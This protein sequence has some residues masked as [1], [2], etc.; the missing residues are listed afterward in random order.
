MTPLRRWAPALRVARREAGRAKGRSAVVLAMIALPVLGVTAADIVIQTSEITGAE[1][2]D[3]RIGGADALVLVQPRTA[4]V[5]QTADPDRGTMTLRGGRRAQPPGL[6]EIEDALGRDIEAVEV[7]AQE[8]VRF[9]TD[10][11][12]A[13]VEI[14]ETDLTSPLTRGLFR[15]DE[16]RVP[17]DRSEIVINHDLAE[18]GFVLGD[19]MTVV[20]GPDLTVVG[21]GDNTS[22]RGRGMAVAQ[23][24]TFELTERPWNRTWLVDAGGAVTWEDVRALNEVGAMALSR[25]VMKDPPSDAELHPSMQGMDDAPVGSEDLAVVGLIVV[26]ALLE[27]VLLAGPAFAVIARRL[28]HSLALMAASGATP[29][30]ARRVVL[31]S[32]LVLG[33]VGTTLGVGLGLLVGWLSLPLVQRFSS[34]FFGPYDVPWLHLAGVAGFGMLSAVLAAV[35]PAWIASRQD[36][37]AVLAGRRGDRRPSR[38][39]PILGL[40]LLGGGVAVAAYGAVQPDNGELLIAASAV[41]TVLGMILLVPVVVAGLARL[42]AVLPLPVRYAV[43]DAARHRARTVPAVAAVAATVVGVVALGIANASDAEQSRATY[44]PLMP[45]GTA[46]VAGP[47]DSDWEGSRAALAE[48]LPGA[49]ISTV[50]GVDSNGVHR[51]TDVQFRVDGRAVRLHSYGSALATQAPIADAI[52]PLVPELGEAERAA[53]DRILREGGAVVFTSRAPTGDEVTVVAREYGPRG[54]GTVVGRA[55]VPAVMIQLPGHHS[56]LQA[57]LSPEAAAAVGAEPVTAG[58]VVSGEEITADQERTATEALAALTPDL[59]LYVERGYQNDDATVIV[60]VVLGALG[61]L[62]MVGGTLTATFLSLSDARPD[63]ATLSAVGAAPRTRRAVAASYAVVI[64]V[65]GA[66]LGVVVG[67]VPGIAV[68]FPL[69]GADWLQE[70]DPTLPGHFLEIPWLLIGTIV[71]VLPLLTALVVGAATRSR[72]PLVARID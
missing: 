40:V 68:T 71:V 22:F 27:V 2:I 66:V 43:R 30:Q 55:T 54:R 59:S 69:T 5:A 16:G 8:F 51:W 64:G 41:I 13:D 28:Q 19:T 49:E 65:V 25:A 14:T 24:G 50:E 60:L 36:V 72:L 45:L 29:R 34:S 32:G 46:A 53:G 39:S 33:V 26:M 44:T 63:L 1:A 48:S 23:P 15:V 12:V 6:D 18:S 47:A 7:R 61:G 62:L 35:V 56:T 57:V 4:E 42:S 58:L 9:E 67:F 17:V 20:G 11:G 38:R 3:R 70:V 31:A 52:P 10:A 21:I 37:T